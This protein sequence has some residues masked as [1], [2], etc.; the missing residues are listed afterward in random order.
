LGDR[1]V[2]RGFR[3]RLSEVRHDLRTPVGHIIGYAEMLEED[4]A[5]GLPG[6]F[7]RDLGLI[8]GAGERLV[9]LIDDHLGAGKSSLDEIDLDEA[10]FQLRMQLNHIT[11]YCEM[12]RE[13]A[14]DLG[15]EDLAEDL[16]R[17]DT[18]QGRLLELIEQ[19]LRDSTFSAPPQGATGAAG[20]REKTQDAAEDRAPKDASGV[21]WLGAG[22]KVLVVDDDPANRELLRRRLMRQGYEVR[23]VDGGREA[24]DLLEDDAVELVLLDLMM[25]GMDGLETLN[26]I[27]QDP[28]RKA[29]PVIMLSASDD[30]DR[31]VQCVLQ[32]AEDY[33][34]KPFNPVLLRARIGAALEKSR[35]RRQFA[36]KL[37]VF[38]SS[39]GDVIPERRIA[40]QVM[41]QLN[42]EFAGEALLVPILWEEEPLLASE[43]FQAQIHAPSETDIYLGILWSRIGSPLPAT[44]VRADGSRY[45]SG[46][47][48]EFEDALAGFRAT[49]RPDMLVYRKTGAPLMSL[50]DRDEVLDRLEQM[51]RLQAYVDRHFRGEDGSYVAAFHAFDGI[52]QFE[53][54]LLTHLRKLVEDRLERQRG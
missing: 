16:A 52:E 17:I 18:A 35:L 22:G 12:L 23:T 37:T 36:K 49:G 46:T 51:D 54:M 30:M 13:E 48:F 34:L 4:M 2:D 10:Q 29:L 31:I 24:L 47:A 1:G 33:L 19:R 20:Q 5:D 40:K 6:E 8:K 43:T 50:E 7:V 26:R 44:I 28:A 38:I 45:D 25:P 42:E 15:R 53:N 11:G 9:A 27:K 41:S 21:A 32:G 14:E 39:P 3:Q